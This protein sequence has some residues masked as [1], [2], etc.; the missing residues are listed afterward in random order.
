MCENA[1]FLRRV[2]SL[3]ITLAMLLFYQLAWAKKSSS[4]KK[5]SGKYYSLLPV[6]T[7]SLVH[8]ERLTNADLHILA[9][10]EDSILRALQVL[11]KSDTVLNSARKL[12]IVKCLLWHMREALRYPNSFAYSFAKL[13]KNVSIV[14]P[15]D[16]SFRIFTW[17][18]SLEDLRAIKQGIL[19][20]NSLDGKAKLY[21]LY[22]KTAQI[23]NL[24]DTITTADAWI[25]A[26][27]YYIHSEDLGRRRVYTLLGIDEHNILSTRKWIEILRFSKDG[28]PY[29]GGPFF[30]WVEDNKESPKA[31]KTKTTQRKSMPKYSKSKLSAG[32]MPELVIS[33]KK[34]KAK[35]KNM[36]SDLIPI[37]ATSPVKLDKSAR[38]QVHKRFM[39]EY[40]KNTVVNLRY[41]KDLKMLI[42]DHLQ[43]SDDA[44]IDRKYTYD[45]DGDYEGFMWQKD[46]WVHIQNVF[47]FQLEGGKVPRAKPIN[48][49]KQIREY[50]KIMRSK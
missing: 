37:P 4:T 18:Y 45:I 42:F 6:N 3:G 43:P 48:F 33:A 25:G 1:S 22:D 10:H 9:K 29:F 35:Q 20:M 13:G 17:Q 46:R 26:M 7:D 16:S 2:W 5:S 15:R 40:T 21:P 34:H 19:Q 27:Y 32:Q 47:N 44:T 8:R 38:P 39:L 31:E 11:Q 30:S 28:T 50:E 41:D 23:R 24:L 14:Y 49:H 12:Q 36:I